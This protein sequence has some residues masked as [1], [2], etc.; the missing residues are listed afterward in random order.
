MDLNQ[1]EGTTA[2]RMDGSDLT[3]KDVEEMLGDPQI[4]LRL[5]ADSAAGAN[6]RLR[7]NLFEEAAMCQEQ[8]R[9]WLDLHQALVGAQDR[10]EA[11]KQIA[12]IRRDDQMRQATANRFFQSSMP[13]SPKVPGI[14][15][16]NPLEG[17]SSGIEEPPLS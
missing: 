1:P 15:P 8:S 11:E 2:M 5:A 12:Q 6:N 14:F 10:R 9:I 13:G 4:A 7:A 17:S 3:P 16:R